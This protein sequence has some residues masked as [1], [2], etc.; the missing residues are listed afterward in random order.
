MKNAK[1]II[2]A[3]IVAIAVLAGLAINVF[4]TLE[5]RDVEL[6]EPPEFP[7]SPLPCAAIP[8]EYVMRYPECADLLLESMNVSG[9]H[10]M[11]M[12]PDMLSAADVP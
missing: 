9:V 1:L 8:T 2:M 10:I 6:C 5:L 3:A 4:V 11:R 12:A 7:S